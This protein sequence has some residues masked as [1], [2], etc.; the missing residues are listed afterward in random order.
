[1]CGRF[2][3]TTPSDELIRLF[4]L[5]SGLS[6][7]PRYNVAPTQQAVVV[8]DS[9][10]GRMAQPCRWGLV[11]SWAP[12]LQRGASLINARSET[13]FTKPT[14]AALSRTQRCV[15]PS[16]GF[17]EWRQT[18]A[19]KLPT[20]FT[21]RKEPILRL[22][23]L[24]STWADDAGTLTYTFTILTTEANRV[25]SPFHH[26]MPVLLSAKGAAQWLKSSTT[27]PEALAPLLK[28]SAENA[29]NLTPVSPRVNNVRNDDRQC[30]APLIT[31]E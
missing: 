8:R 15:I 31:P 23:G 20:L 19:G 29:L 17:Y 24:W 28:P 1:M 7:E 14:F 21:P 26:R 22:A 3:Q 4:R 10:T 27:D 30:W 13:V 12:N 25:M 2:A 9:A 6:A 18:P 11:P 5:V 16:S